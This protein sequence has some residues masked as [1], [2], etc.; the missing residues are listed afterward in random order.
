MFQRPSSTAASSIGTIQCPA[1][2]GGTASL[3]TADSTIKLKKI[4]VGDLDV[5]QQI[6]VGK[7]ASDETVSKSIESTTVVATDTKTVY[8]TAKHGQIETLDVK[9]DMRVEG[10]MSVGDNTVVR[11]SLGAEF[12]ATS[13][14]V[15][16]TAKIGELS[17]IKK[18]TTSDSWS[19]GSRSEGGVGW[20]SGDTLMMSLTAD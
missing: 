8:L 6:N 14:I 1:P 5:L 16:L 18:I 10:S 17:G 15:A 3:I 7:L 19:V 12:I 9:Q 20:W 4:T 2:I 11:G 13:N